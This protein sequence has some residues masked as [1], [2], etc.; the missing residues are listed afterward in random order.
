MKRALMILPFIL[1]LSLVSASSVYQINYTYPALNP[2]AAYIVPQILKYEPFPVNVGNWFDLWVKVQN[3]GPE[4]ARNAEFTL[5]PNYPFE[6]NDSL[7]RDYGLLY[8]TKHAYNANQNYDSTQLILKFRVK[9]ADNAPEGNSSIKLQIAPDKTSGSAIVYD[10]PIQIEKTKTT[11]DVKLRE[12]NAQESSFVVINIGDNL[13]RAVIVDIKSQADIN[14]LTGSEP[15][16]LG[17]L[18]QGEFT[19]AHLK[20]VPSKSSKD[21]TLAISY[22]DSA[23]VRTMTEQTVAITPSMLQNS[24]IQNSQSP[25]SK[26]VFA[27]I[28]LV[29]GIFLVMLVALIKRKR[30]HK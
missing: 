19:I 17:D 6:S 21:I 11:F 8:G 14:F 20:A 2:P 7:V 4:D 16:S 13:A 25:L 18:N 28:G 10:L 12:I 30:A 26:W 5:I 15:A 3:I 24:C 23:G 29:T 9:V 27:L 22:T 1:L